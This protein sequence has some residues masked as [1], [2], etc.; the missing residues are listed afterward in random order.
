[1]VAAQEVPLQSWFRTSG[2][3]AWLWAGSQID[4]SKIAPLFYQPAQV[5]LCRA[6]RL[7]GQITEV[8]KKNVEVQVRLCAKVTHSDLGLTPRRASKLTG[9]QTHTPHSVGPE[10]CEKQLKAVG[11]KRRRIR[12]TAG[13]QTADQTRKRHPAGNR[14]GHLTSRDAESGALVNPQQS[15]WNP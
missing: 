8:M 1:M 5:A 9:E 2:G 10:R 12:T 14:S 13:M 15:G 11:E 7:S 4:E 6:R 3:P